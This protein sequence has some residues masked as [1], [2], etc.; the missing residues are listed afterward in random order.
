MTSFLR[1]DSARCIGCRTCEVA[2]A[3][4]HTDKPLSGGNFLPRLH[5]VKQAHV[6]VPVMCHHCENAPCVAACPTQA[7]VQG[8]ERVEIYETRC[9]GCAGCVVACPF[10]VISLAGRGEPQP[11]SVIKCDLCVGRETGPACVSVCPTAA[12]EKVSRDSVEM[13]ARQRREQTALSALRHR[14]EH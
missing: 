13:T 1:A 10:G 14:E 4:A 8:L 2:C 7:L 12:L 3:A 6:S 9:I 5:V 11:V